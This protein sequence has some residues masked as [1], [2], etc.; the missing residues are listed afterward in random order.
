MK[1]SKYVGKYDYIDY[2]TKQKPM[3]FFTSIEVQAGLSN[4]LEKLKNANQVVN[5]V[6][7]EDDEEDDEEKKEYDALEYYHQCI[8]NGEELSESDPRVI[9]G[10][11]IDKM[12]KDF[13]KKIYSGFPVFDFDEK[14]YCYNGNE[15]NAEKTKEIILNNENAIMFQPTFIY[16]SLITKSDA[17]VKKG[18]K[19]YIIE[20]KATSSAKIYHYLDLFFQKNVI[21]NQEYFPDT[22]E[23]DYRICLIKYE[24]CDKGRTTFITSNCFNVTKSVTQIGKKAKED[25]SFEE[26]L[27]VKS[28]LKTGYKLDKN[29]DA[30]VGISFNK[31]M[32]NNFEEFANRLTEQQLHERIEFF[33]KIN[34]SFNKATEELIK[35][36]Q[37]ISEKDYP[38][39]FL[40]SKEDNSDF[41]KTTFWNELKQIYILKGYLPFK[42]SGNVIDQGKESIIRIREHDIKDIDDSLIK[43]SEKNKSKYERCFLNKETI[44]YIENC[45]NLLNSLKEKKVYFDFET[46]NTAIRSFDNTPPFAQIITQCSI[47]KSSD[48][49]IPEWKCDN[50]VCDPKNITVKFLK[51]M[52]D[53]L[54]EG[55]NASY[56]VY[57]KSFESSRLKE[58]IRYIND[59]EYTKK[60][61]TIRA[62][63]Y[64]LADFF[65]CRKDYIVMPELYGWY[66]IKK[67]LALIEEVDKGIFNECDCKDYKTLEIKNGGIC[68]TQTIKRFFDLLDDNGWKDLE[69]ELKIYCEND[70]RAMIAVELFIKKIVRNKMEELGMNKQLMDS[71]H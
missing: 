64:D 60:I 39:D 21:E 65:D 20:T 14:E 12:S 59:P 63:L 15:I 38:H 40:P 8:E 66:S 50:L 11:I 30:Y 22:A 19:F 49:P 68:Q 47:I 4:E 67:V 10:N 18:N 51:G 37:T 55:P 45:L 42:Y 70:V 5:L 35:H 31:T 41:R 7:E 16:G 1:K 32:N 34:N 29:T 44:I 2:Y 26:Q 9:E 43:G 36:K 6:D 52:V 28:F 62:N 23:Y 48:K 71:I 69:K 13:V 46:I 57:N 61:Q 53:K 17:V 54:Y 58:C 56:I 24:L 33:L 25:L 3:W 27:V